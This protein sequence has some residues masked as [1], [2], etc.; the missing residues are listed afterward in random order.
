[1]EAIR[2][3]ERVTGKQLVIDLPESFQD[4]QV[5]I[6]ILSLGVTETPQAG[7][8]RHPPAILKQRTVI[9]DDLIEPAVPASD[10]ESG[11]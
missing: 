7:A 9:R 10:W 2:R 3:I 4:Q 6:I 8:R 1:M 5:E 11:R